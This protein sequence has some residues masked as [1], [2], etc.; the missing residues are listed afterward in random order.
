MYIYIYIHTTYIYIYILSQILTAP[1]N[2]NGGEL[3]DIFKLC[4]D[5]FDEPK[6]LEAQE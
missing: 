6:P 2:L 5:D 1:R 3:A 4:T